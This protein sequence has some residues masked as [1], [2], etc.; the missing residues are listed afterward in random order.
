[1]L[2]ALALMALTLSGFAAVRTVQAWRRVSQQTREWMRHAVPLALSGT[3]L[4]AYAIDADQPVIA[5]VGLFRPRLRVPRG[6]LDALPPAELAAS[7]AHE[8]GHQRALDNLKRL[9]MCAAPDLLRPLG[10]ARAL[11]R[12]WAAA[13]EHCAD[14]MAGRDGAEARCALA[15]ALVKVARLTTS[16]TP[17]LDHVSTLI[18]G[19]GNAGRLRAPLA[20]GQAAPIPPRSPDAY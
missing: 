3:A 8:L 19:G 7:V 9:A 14:R 16:T 11:E 4:P 17:V 20:D 18:A 5:L 15:S 12:R 1:T 10:A 6:L 2:A 13:A